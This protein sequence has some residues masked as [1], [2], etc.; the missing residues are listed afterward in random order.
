M[1]LHSAP[2]VVYPLGRSYFSGGLLFGLWLA[3]LIS[4]LLWCYLTRQLDW[5]MGSALLAV[6]VAG[7][8]ARAGWKSAPSGRLAWDGEVWR[9]ESA[10]YQTGMAEHELSVIADF[11]HR[12]LL[13]IENQAHAS[14]WLWV[15]RS[16]MPERWLDLRRAVYSSHKSPVTSQQHDFQSAEASSLSSS[17]VAVSSDMPSVDFPRIKP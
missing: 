5:R 13:R 10:S 6:L 11:Q 2:P 9:W 16:A 14:L 7:F 12:L 1:T 15:E 3:G 8:A 17:A 4:V